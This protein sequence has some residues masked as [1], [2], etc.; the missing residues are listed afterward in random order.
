M[1]T[2]VNECECVKGC[3]SVCVCVSPTV[4]TDWGL[5]VEVAGETG[6]PTGACKGRREDGEME[7]SGCL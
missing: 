5:R 6:E 3:E 7:I 1:S 4:V 2:G